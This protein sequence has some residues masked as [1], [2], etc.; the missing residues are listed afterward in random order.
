MDIINLSRFAARD[1]LTPVWEL[2]SCSFHGVSKKNRD[3]LENGEKTEGSLVL[4]L[5]WCSGSLRLPNKL[6]PLCHA[7]TPRGPAHMSRHTSIPP[8]NLANYPPP[9][10]APPVFHLQPSIQVD[11]CWSLQS[12][13]GRDNTKVP[14]KNWPKLFTACFGFCFSVRPAESCPLAHIHTNRHTENMLFVINHLKHVQTR[15]KTPKRNV[16][17]KG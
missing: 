3:L 13:S 2:V 17:T 1:A 4:R 10:N 14:L 11:V 8:H 9:P 12:S 16:R 7:P 15:E 6:T 5:L